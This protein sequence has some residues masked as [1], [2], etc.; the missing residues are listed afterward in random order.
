MFV[1]QAVFVG[2][3]SQYFCEKNSLEEELSALKNSNSTELSN[4]KEEELQVLTRDAYFFASAMTIVAFTL[5]FDHAWT[6][7]ISGTMGM[8]HRILLTAAIYEK[9]SNKAIFI[10][11][12]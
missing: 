1:G 9:A 5:A 2:N 6:F 12:L 8:K 3:L 4:S 11:C 7:Y 10:S